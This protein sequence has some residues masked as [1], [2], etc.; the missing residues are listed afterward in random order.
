MPVDSKL[1]LELRIEQAQ[2]GFPE[3]IQARDPLFSRTHTR[4]WDNNAWAL[5]LV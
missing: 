2:V 5:D 3:L 4:K 1:Y